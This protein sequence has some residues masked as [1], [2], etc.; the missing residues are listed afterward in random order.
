MVLSI[1]ILIVISNIFN[2]NLKQDSY[3]QA[4]QMK[5]L[6]KEHFEQ[7]VQ[8]RDSVESVGTLTTETSIWPVP[9]N[10]NYKG[11]KIKA[12]KYLDTAK[13]ESENLFSPVL[14]QNQEV[15]SLK[16][17]Q[18]ILDRYNY[19]FNLPDQLKQYLRQKE[20]EAI[21]RE[22]L[23]VKSTIKDNELSVVVKGMEEVEIIIQQ[24]REVLLKQLERIDRPVGEMQRAVELLQEI[25][26]EENPLHYLL[27][28]RKHYVS[29]Q[30]E[31]CSIQYASLSGSGTINVGGENNAKNK[32]KISRVYM[33]KGS[34]ILLK[35][36]FDLWELSVRCIDEEVVQGHSKFTLEDGNKCIGQVTYEYLKLI[37]YLLIGEN[38]DDAFNDGG[39]G[40][41][42]GSEEN[43]L[44]FE[45]ESSENVSLK[46]I[47]YALT[48]MGKLIDTIISTSEK[49]FQRDEKKHKTDPFAIIV[50]IYI[51]ILFYYI[52]IWC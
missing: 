42:D 11:G 38:D 7:F 33:D 50:Y 48:S 22:Y 19:V 23:R 32:V 4:A 34:E 5:K 28:V 15:K 37:K 3:D 21:V 24:L 39:D 14:K 47:R 40:S 31:N 16:F 26:C 51:Y 17:A 35:Y 30:L 27:N 52:E 2:R 9:P 25:G 10:D 29:S 20:Y 49:H 46:D 12:E 1:F 8:C 41:E 13:D 6:V 36:L 45:V 44:D 43:E 18:H